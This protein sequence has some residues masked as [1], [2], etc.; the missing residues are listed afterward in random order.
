MHLRFNY[1]IRVVRIPFHSYMFQTLE[2]PLPR[3]CHSTVC[4]SNG[5]VVIISQDSLRRWSGNVWTDTTCSVYVAEIRSTL[6]QGILNS[7]WFCTIPFGPVLQIQ[8]CVS[9]VAIPWT[10]VSL[11][12]P[13]VYGPV[14]A[15][16]PRY[17]SFGPK[18]DKR[19]VAPCGSSVLDSVWFPAMA[20]KELLEKSN[21]MYSCISGQYDM[22]H[23][24][25]V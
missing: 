1:R 2:Q 12:S 23:H 7:L 16:N 5:L 14:N 4:P 6:A 13:V 24:I 3:R 15:Q 9:E 10:G 22:Y 11:S 18:P 25:P 19:P 8:T 17:T 21:L 20:T